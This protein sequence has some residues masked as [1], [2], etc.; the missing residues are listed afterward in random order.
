MCHGGVHGL[1]HTYVRRALRSQL[2]E[3]AGYVGF[4]GKAGKANQAPLH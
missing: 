4:S 2:T 1:L 3:I